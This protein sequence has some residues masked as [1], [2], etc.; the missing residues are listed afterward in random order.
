MKM[1]KAL[2]ALMQEVARDDTY[3]IERAKVDFA[4]ALES[5]RRSAG[6]SYKDIADRIKS[7]AAYISKVFRGDSNLTI[8]SMV[9]LAHATGGCL[10]VRVMSKEEASKN[11]GPVLSKIQEDSVRHRPVIQATADTITDSAVN[12]N[13]YWVQHIFKRAA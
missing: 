4:A 10:E 1:S 7:S 8:E 11:W 13:V 12:D 3:W 9:K 2:R 5:Q 6:L